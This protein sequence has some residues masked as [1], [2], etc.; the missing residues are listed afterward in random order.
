MASG[1]PR[2]PTNDPCVVLA[3]INGIH[4]LLVGAGACGQQNNA[5]AIVNFAKL[6]GIKNMQALIDNA[7]AYRKHPRRRFSAK[8]RLVTPS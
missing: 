5:D 4:A 1:G 7:I 2:D 8:R 3:G 6:P